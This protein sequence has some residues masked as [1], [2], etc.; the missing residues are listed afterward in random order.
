VECLKSLALARNKITVGF[1]LSVAEVVDS[2]T[3]EEGWVLFGLH[4]PNV[5]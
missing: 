5:R 2:D 4:A 1:K 3:V